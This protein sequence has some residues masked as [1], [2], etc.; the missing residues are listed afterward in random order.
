MD[1]HTEQKVLD[2]CH[3]MLH[4]FVACSHSSAS[5]NQQST[6]TPLGHIN[7]Q[8]AAYFQRVCRC[9]QSDTPWHSAASDTA[10]L[11]A[12]SCHGPG[13]KAH[14]RRPTLPCWALYTLGTLS[15]WHTAQ[16]ACLPCI[17]I[18][19]TAHTITSSTVNFTDDGV[20]SAS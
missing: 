15:V 11:Q 18:L 17:H 16:V 1:I 14:K 9:L 8:H 10:H 2:T 12:A 7:C 6:Q 19:C 3:G 20:S 4:I 13:P 5:I